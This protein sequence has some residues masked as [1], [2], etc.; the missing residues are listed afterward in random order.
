[1]VFLKKKISVHYFAQI[2]CKSTMPK[3]SGQEMPHTDALE[4]SA[5]PQDSV[6]RY[7]CSSVTLYFPVTIAF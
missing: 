4:K 3:M 6:P 1:M 2:I 5:L 7:S